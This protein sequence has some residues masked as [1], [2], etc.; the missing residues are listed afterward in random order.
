VDLEAV[1]V[2]RVAVQ[3]ALGVVN[4]LLLLRHE[5]VAA[6]VG[7]AGPRVLGPRRAAAQPAALQNSKSEDSENQ[8][9]T[10]ANMIKKCIFSAGNKT[11]NETVHGMSNRRFRQLTIGAGR[12][13]R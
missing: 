7:D 12:T 10:H 13:C 8:V 4:L 5:A 11:E 3:V 6:V 2:V 9:I 1:V